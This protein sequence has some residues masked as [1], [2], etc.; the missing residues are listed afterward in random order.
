MYTYGLCAIGECLM[1]LIPTGINDMGATLLSANAGGAPANVLAMFQKLGGKTAFIGKVGDDGFGKFL[2][3]NLQNAG[4]DTRGVIVDKLYNTT[5]AIVHLSD[6]GDRSFSFY[7]KH[8]ADVMLIADEVSD[9]VINSSAMFHFGSVSLTDEPSRTAT[10]QAVVAAKQNGAL[11]SYD[12]NY[13]PL[14]WYSIKDAKCVMREGAKLADII[15]VSDEELTLLTDETDYR[16]G[17]EKLTNMGA[18]LVF[19]TLGAQGA[20]Y[21]NRNADGMVQTYNIKTVDTTGAG[22]AFFG[23]VLWQLR[24][25]SRAALQ[26]LNK[27]E[28]ENIVRFANAAGSLTTTK[29][30]AIPAM[31]HKSDILALMNTAQNL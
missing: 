22:D 10:L 12:P 6:T 27:T 29:K 26:A 25:T 11:I 15:K 8:C 20:Y 28:L 2:V 16:K 1:D 23:A 7:R 18:S 21:Y 30:G 9:E 17:A 24:D 5:L 14:L 13:R 3:D 4:I 31:P 19:V